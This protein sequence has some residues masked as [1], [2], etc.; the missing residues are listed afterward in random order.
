[1][2]TLRS[3]YFAPNKR[4]Q[5]AAS[6][7]KL[8]AR[9]ERSDGVAL[10]QAGL[11]DM[12]QKMPR[13]TRPDGSLDG[14]FG[15]ETYDAVRTY[16]SSK[17]APALTADG[18][19]GPKTL[20]ALD[21]DLLAR[22]GHAPKVPA[23]PAKPEPK[24]P[25]PPNVPVNINDL[26]YKIGTA[27]PQVTRD[28]GAGAW[29]S[30]PKSALAITQ[31]AAILTATTRGYTNVY[32]GPNA[33]RHMNH[34][35]GNSGAN[36]TI[37][38]EDMIRSTD[39]AKKMMVLEWRQAQ[40]FIQQLPVGTHHF[41]SKHAESS[42]NYKGETSDWFFAIGGYS[43]WGKGTATVSM[44]GA[45]KKYDVVFEYNFFDRYNWDG[46]KKVDIAGIE[47]T[48]EFM[49]EFHRQGLAKEF[50]CY[51]K[52]T[53]RF[54]WVGNTNYPTNHDITHGPGR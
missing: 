16:Q 53:R 20:G 21:L 17:K 51:G 47:I 11:C 4:L 33:T 22:Q 41:T 25:P 54:S 24:M 19:A 18:I 44:Q 49:G 3:R 12:G 37:D 42:Y 32:P 27:D 43:F 8:I 48:D 52:V 26:N 15:Q 6:G 13:S 36:Y 5:N 14:V 29:N 35:F 50:D 46:G 9:G 10:L 2:P 39:R 7:G 23:K 40:R 30:K 31:M 45:Q 34:Y 38:L 1:M 28:P